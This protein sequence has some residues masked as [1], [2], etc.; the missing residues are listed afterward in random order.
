MISQR[1]V[2][3]RGRL[4]YLRQ[5][6]RSHIV[7][8]LCRALAQGKTRLIPDEIVIGYRIARVCIVAQISKLCA[9]FF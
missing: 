3:F 2:H 6:Y 1:H 4:G 5:L 8:M 9:L 7:I